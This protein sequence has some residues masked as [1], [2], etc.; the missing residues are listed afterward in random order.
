MKPFNRKTII[1]L[2]LL[3]FCTTN[4]ETILLR[5]KL[6][7]GQVF[8]S[9]TITKQLVE[10]ESNGQKSNTEVNMEN[11]ATMKVLKVLS[12]KG[13]L[14]KF[15]MDSTKFENQNTN[16]QNPIDKRFTEILSESLR[17]IG[18]Q[19]SIDSCWH[20]LDV[21]G[22]EKLKEVALSKVI[23]ELGLPT[24]RIKPIIDNYYDKQFSKEAIKKMFRDVSAIYPINPVDVNQEWKDKT[25]FEHPL[26]AATKFSIYSVSKRVYGNLRIDF[27][28]R[29][30]KDKKTEPAK[31][32]KLGTRKNLIE[33]TMSGYMLMDS[34]T[35]WTTDMMAESD[36]IIT[37]EQTDTNNNKSKI[38]ART[39]GTVVKET[40][41]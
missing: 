37:I 7:E 14:I 32:N 3:L 11:W 24:E 17:D 26:I 22:F 39:K 27:K 13:Y 16:N 25:A 28:A 35:C 15:T 41:K 23:T 10:Q 20:V 30:K 12:G 21:S 4:S 5:L 40:I 29:I 8:R 18:F 2:P 9:K 31:I 1:I 19:L 38:K 36:M 33:G 34:K 6:H